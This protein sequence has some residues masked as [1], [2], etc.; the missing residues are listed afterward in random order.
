MWNEDDDWWLF[1]RN[2]YMRQHMSR[3]QMSFTAVTGTQ[4]SSQSQRNVSK[5]NSLVT[6]LSFL[7]TIYSL[8]C[9][10]VFSLGFFVDNRFIF[11]F[12]F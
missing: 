11:Y 1:T 2:A 4:H 6:G 7:L 8:L 12:F 5:G 3:G 10:L 9:T